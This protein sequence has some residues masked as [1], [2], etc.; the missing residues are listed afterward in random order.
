M[1]TRRILSHRH[2]SN[3]SRKFNLAVIGTGRMGR[4]RIQHILENPRVNLSYIIAENPSLAYAAEMEY[5]TKGVDDLACVLSDKNVDG[6]WISTPTSSH[7]DV[8]LQAAQ[9]KKHVAVEK[10]VS[11]TLSELNA[12]YAATEKH[13]VHLLCSFQRRFDNSYMCSALVRSMC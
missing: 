9:A 13:G 10:P 11:G 7:L 2:F 3:T 8:I 12:A 4:I 6:I 1:L 5:N